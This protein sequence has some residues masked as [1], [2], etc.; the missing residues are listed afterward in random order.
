MEM[1]RITK[2]DVLFEREFERYRLG[3]Y[4]LLGL[5]FLLASDI[6]QTILH[7]GFEELYILGIIVT[8]RFILSFLL[9]R[10]MD[11]EIIRKRRDRKDD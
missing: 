5:D 7:P 11:I 9:N 6:I 2:A 3:T 8:I 10:E 1:K 4:L